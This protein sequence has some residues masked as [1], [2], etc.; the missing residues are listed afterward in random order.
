MQ[1]PLCILHLEDDAKDAELL[2]ALLE[3]EGIICQVTRVDSQ[4]DFLAAIEHGGFDLILADHTLPSFD[5]FS[6]LKI[7]LE[8]CPDVPFI[9][10]SGTLG[11][12]VAIEALKI[13]ATDYVLKERLS[14]IVP[15]VQRALREA[16]ERAERK[17]AEEAL[18]K[19]ERQ[20]R[21][22]F[23][24]A[25]V[26]IAIVT[27]AGQ[28]L[29]SN[30]KFQQ[31]LGYSAEEFR[32]LPFAQ[33]TH[34]DD[35]EKDQALF[36]ELIS[37]QRDHYQIEKRYYRKDGS[38]VW[39]NL[40]VSLVRDDRGEPLFGIAI[41][42]DITER[43]RAEE[44]LLQVTQELVERNTE[45]WRLQGELRGVEPLAALGRVTGTIAHEL[46]TPLNSVL[47]Y[48]QLLA[49]EPLS[50][51]ARESLGVIEAQA[52]R[53]ID[54]IQHYLTQTR[55]AFQRRHPLNMN[56][57]IRETLVLLK[58]IF[59]THLVEVT[60]GLADTLPVLRGDGASLQR[61]LINVL[62]NAVDA[63]EGGGTVSVVTRGGTFP[64]AA[65][66]GVLVEIRDTG[67]GIPPELLPRIFELFVTTKASGKGT[68]LG[69]ALSQEI[70]KAHGGTIDIRSQVGAGTCVRIF[71]PTEERSEGAP[72]TEGRT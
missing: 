21:A 63:M 28:A 26:G 67:S 57:L 60:T 15:A 27:T 16:K 61:V 29:E 11:E 39:G 43:K 19:S 31:M 13:G 36:T 41:V 14:R 54:I 12:E 64:E 42:E 72:L 30:R 24:Q 46:G 1:S 50:D 69:L 4:A 2:Q 48:S 66:P 3:S 32:S 45:L 38:V 9:F 44:R 40:T 56:T 70:V 25:A 34:P 37:G 35:L 58:P 52:R 17:R 8:K 5:G 6:A 7:T 10:V 55:G 62:T 23:D 59:H 53:M 20:F 33:V 18:K 49:Q 47:G 22:L 68:G 71:L 51:D 65:R